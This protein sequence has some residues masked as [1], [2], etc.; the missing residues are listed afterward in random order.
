[1]VVIGRG[2]RSVPRVVCNLFESAIAKR[3]LPHSIQL[4]RVHLIPDSAQSLA[5][6]KVSR[7]LGRSLATAAPD[8]RNRGAL[9]ALPVT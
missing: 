2:K 9:V 3:H 5:L 6:R 4:A 8:Y 7:K 1:M